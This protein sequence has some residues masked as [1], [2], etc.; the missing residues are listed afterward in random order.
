MLP[1]AP[2][3]L[4]IFSGSNARFMACFFDAIL[5]TTG[6]DRQPTSP[7]RNQL[8]PQR[9]ADGTVPIEA[10]AATLSAAPGNSQNKALRKKK[11]CTS[12]GWEAPRK[13]V[14]VMN[15]KAGGGGGWQQCALRAVLVGIEF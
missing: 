11:K 13:N 8:T 6:A 7:T 15:G 4:T 9:T 12:S 14:C 3:V 2:Y 5:R 10:A 1:N